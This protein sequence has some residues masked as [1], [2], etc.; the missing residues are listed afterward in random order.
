MDTQSA[1]CI[2]QPRSVHTSVTSD[3]GT[4]ING[5]FLNLLVFE[6]GVRVGRLA[7]RL[8]GALALPAPRCAKIAL[9][10][11]LHDAGKLLIATSVWSVPGPLTAFQRTL[12]EDHPSLGADL[13]EIACRDLSIEGE[14]LRRVALMHHERW[15]GKGYP[16]GIAGRAIPLEARLVAIA[17]SYDALTTERPY[18]AAWSSARALAQLRAESARQFD[19]QLVEAFCALIGAEEASDHEA[20]AERSWEQSARTIY[21]HVLRLSRGETPDH[22]AI[23]SHITQ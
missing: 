22:A 3:V 2:S 10:A 18:K 4:P 16:Y 14:V 12:V 8:A 7:T 5:E 23:S 13:L 15:D 9:A 11:S 17:D 6:H 20:F 19:P 21:Q 1:Q